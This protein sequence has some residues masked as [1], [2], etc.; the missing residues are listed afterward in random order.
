[1]IQELDGKTPKIGANTFVAPSAD[2]IGEVTIGEGSS[3][4]FQC[5][6]RGD[7][8]PIEIGDNTNIQDGTVIHGTHRVWGTKIGDN[9]TVGHKAMLHGCEIGDE[10][11]VGMGSI[12]LDGSV[13]EPRSFLAAGSLLTEGSRAQSGW[14]HMGRPAKP[15]RELKAEEL[16]FLRQSANNYLLYKSWYDHSLENS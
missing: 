4:W 1:M 2:I 8:M 14:M 13:M 6:L 12:L 16:N 9:V 7:V 10:A 3:I 5:V 15:V 11:F